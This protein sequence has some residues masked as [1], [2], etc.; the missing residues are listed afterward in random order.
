MTLRVDEHLLK[1]TVPATLPVA[2]EDSV[3]FGFDAD[4]VH[5]FD[6]STGVSFA[7]QRSA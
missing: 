2:I 1:A 4:K 3:R 5:C 7:H 6:G